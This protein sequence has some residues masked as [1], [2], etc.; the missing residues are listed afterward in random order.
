MPLST[1]EY[2]AAYNGGFN[3]FH[4][5]VQGGR[6]IGSFL[7]GLAKAAVPVLLKGGSKVITSLVQGQGLKQSLKSGLSTVVQEGIDTLQGTKTRRQKTI[8]RATPAKKP[9]QTRRVTTD[10][11]S[12]GAGF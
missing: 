7:S 12:K 5:T 2:L 8:N 3:K 1:E 6:G 4:G 10:N 11:T 9:R